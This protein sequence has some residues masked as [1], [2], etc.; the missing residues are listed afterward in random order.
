MVT[1][2]L[3]LPQGQFPVAS[4][5]MKFP[6]TNVADGARA[7]QE[8]AVGSVAGNHIAA[9]VFDGAPLTVMPSAAC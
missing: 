6:A 2:P 8:D 3:P 4:V 9:D 7:S 1:P 5:P